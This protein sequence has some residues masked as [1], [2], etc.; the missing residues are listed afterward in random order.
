MFASPRDG[1]DVLAKLV[2]YATDL[3]LWPVVFAGFALLNIMNPLFIATLV[4]ALWAV[5]LDVSLVEIRK[6]LGSNA[7]FVDYFWPTFVLMALLYST[8]QAVRRAK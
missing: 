8:I 3:R 4:S 7:T 2:A 6:E 5:Y 1:I